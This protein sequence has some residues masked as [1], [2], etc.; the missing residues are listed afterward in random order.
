[1]AAGYAPSR[2]G[3]PN[4]TIVYVDESRGAA[5]IWRRFLP[6]GVT[7]VMACH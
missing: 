4:V 5:L 1:M 7:P 3:A 2:L 6:P